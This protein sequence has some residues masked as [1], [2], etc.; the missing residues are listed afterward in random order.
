A[1][2]NLSYDCNP[3][4]LLKIFRGEGSMQAS[5]RAAALYEEFGVRVER[6]DA[7]AAVAQEPA[8]A[9][10]AERIS[11][12]V[13]YPDDES[14]DAFKFTQEIA[15]VAAKLGADFRYGSA[16]GRLVRDGDRITAVETHGG[17]VVG[18]LFVLAL[19]SYSPL[20]ART[21]GLTLPIYPAKGYSITIDT[22]GW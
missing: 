8:L 4:G 15:A 5:L 10:I 13:F 6:L 19:G 3:P 12:A 14:G 18:D 22:P 2:E 20:V 1:L 7:R 17:L 21:V 9:P 11:G 16:V